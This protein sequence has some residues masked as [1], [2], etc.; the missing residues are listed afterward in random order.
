M[1][2]VVRRAWRRSIVCG[3]AGLAAIA[4]L[5]HEP[6]PEKAPAAERGIA[7]AASRAASQLAGTEVGTCE[8]GELD[9][10]VLLPTGAPTSL[11][12]DEARQVVAQARSNMAAPPGTID[13]AKFA[14]ATADWLD[15]HGMWSGAAD[16][17][18]GAAVRR[19]ADRLL[20]E[21]EAPPG[22]GP[23]TAALEVGVDLQAWA[24]HLRG[25]FDEA[26][27]AAAPRPP[28]DGFALA[29]ATPFE[30]GA[31]TRSA[32]DLA[33]ELGREV[34]G[35]RAAYG[36][37]ID[38]YAAAARER[39]APGLDVEGWS[40]AVIAAAL[41]SYI[42]QLDAHGA[43]APLD[44]EMSIYDLALES[45]PPERIWA[46]MTRTSL[47]VRV[48]R[49]A[50]VPLADGDVI[51]AVHD[52]PL[53][54]LSVEQA[55]QF[56][57][58]SDVRPV[59]VSVLRPH[60]AAPIELNV[61]PAPPAPD[62]EPGPELHVDVVRYADGVAGVITIPDVPDDLGPKLAAALD[63]VR[64]EGDVRGVL[65][66]VRGNG[67]GSTDGAIGALGLFLPGAALFPMRRRDGGIELESAPETPDDRRW[68]GPL[69]A[70]VDGDSAS[71]AEMLAGAIGAYRRGYV[72]GER[73]YGK[74]CAQEYLDDDAHAGVL[75][76]TTLLFALPDG[77][78]VQKVGL[79]PQI[80]LSLPPASEK[81]ASMARALGPW[82]GPD[83][84]DPGRVREVPWPAHGGRV[85]P[86]PDETVCRALR[87]L[88]A[89]P[90]AAR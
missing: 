17:P 6:A 41:R 35:A 61:A 2:E 83:V 66:D 56:A 51:L 16:A 87:A 4:L 3:V 75:R 20:A 63:R 69:G 10:A 73:T 45:T 84:R 85:G 7:R 55:E 50:L 76:L 29:S 89:A 23:C 27:R 72:V 71:A 74:G 14:E 47:G 37:A 1:P 54:G 39:A 77:S 67:G 18:P 64:R 24:S 26:Y 78:P 46:E 53:A 57:V 22:S 59:R 58:L 42:P 65:L 48:D 68:R 62:Q 34:G 19:V 13:A 38:A 36:V 8:D 28:A 9:R 81:E 31:V 49:G 12:C 32:R 86:C 11:D 79:T 33:R 80:R 5:W 82:R 25:L 52:V 30:D 21:I 88:G 60:A 40:R 70:L 15:P 43:W 90:A 44:E